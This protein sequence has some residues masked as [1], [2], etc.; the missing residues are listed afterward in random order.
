[1]LKF[2]LALFIS[3]AAMLF[4]VMRYRIHLHI[5]YQPRRNRRTT[6]HGTRRHRFGSC[7][8]IQE[9]EGAA[10]DSGEAAAAKLKVFQDLQSALVNLGASKAEARER[11]TVAIAQAPDADFDALILRAMQSGGSPEARR[12]PRRMMQ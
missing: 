5:E 9:P 3:T 8:S 1:V 11:A 12:N 6:I 2:N 4:Y 10:V 7:P